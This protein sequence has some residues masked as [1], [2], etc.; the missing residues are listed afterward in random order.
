[1]AQSVERGEVLQSVYL[2]PHW[3]SLHTPSELLLLGASKSHSCIN[4]TPQTQSQTPVLCSRHPGPLGRRQVPGPRDH[5]HAVAYSYTTQ[6][7]R[8]GPPRSLSRTCMHTALICIHTVSHNTTCD[9][10]QHITHAPSVMVPHCTLHPLNLLLRA[11]TENSLLHKPPIGPT[12]QP[13]VPWADP[14]KG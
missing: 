10:H 3:H 1:M 8:Q 4:R 14:S 6:S 11:S 9:A 13:D 12:L 2:F 7:S 5:T